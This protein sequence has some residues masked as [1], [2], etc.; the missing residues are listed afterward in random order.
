MQK[1]KIFVINLARVPERANYMLEETNRVGLSDVNLFTA[2]DAEDLNLQSTNQFYNPR[3]WGKYWELS[4]SE[5]ACFES[6]LSLWRQCAQDNQTYVI[7]EDDIVISQSAKFIL[8]ELMNYSNYFDLIHLDSGSG[9]HRIGK[10]TS[11][12]GVKISRICETVNSAAFYMLSPEG[13]R[14]LVKRAE[15]GYCDHADDFLTR[16]LEGHRAY[17]LVPAVAIQGMFAEPASVHPTIRVSQRT[18]SPRIN[19]PPSKGPVTYR[20]IKEMRRT[21]RRKMQKYVLDGKLIR[22]GGNVGQIPLANDLPKY[23]S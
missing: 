5:V 15:Q 10:P 19:T 2:I 17:Q 3:A 14:K 11:W 16:P 12:G 21:Y 6:H 13:A 9:I 23:R 7:C 4:K 20:L 8:P 1:M 18:A 22:S